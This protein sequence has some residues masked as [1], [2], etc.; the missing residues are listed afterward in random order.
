MCEQSVRINF[1]FVRH[2]FK[3]MAHV[4]HSTSLSAT[5]AR[6]AISRNVVSLR[7]RS[8]SSAVVYKSRSLS[9]RF[10]PNCRA[11]A[12]N[13]FESVAVKSAPKR[14]VPSRKSAESLA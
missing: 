7:S 1:S 9:Q 6:F 3:Q 11:S 8:T 13:R 10:A 12:A 14:G 4:V 5:Y 2:S